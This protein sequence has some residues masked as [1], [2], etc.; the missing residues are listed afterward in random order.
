MREEIFSDAYNTVSDPIRSLN[1]EYLNQKDCSA[2]STETGRVSG[3][4]SPVL[5]TNDSILSQLPT[6]VMENSKVKPFLIV[7]YNE[8]IK[9]KNPYY[10]YLPLEVAE[11]GEE[12]IILDWV[13]ETVRISFFFM[14]DK[15]MYSIT[16]YDAQRN[17]YFQKIEEITSERY[18]EIASQILGEIA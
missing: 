2:M 16:R 14:K 3:L 4:V 12:G 8:Y 1:Y 5:N 15:N 7:L 13:F 17:S 11:I 10:T 6:D 9:Q 18:Q